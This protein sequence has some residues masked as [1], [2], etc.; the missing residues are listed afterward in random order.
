MRSTLCPTDQTKSCEGAGSSRGRICAVPSDRDVAAFDERAATYD[1]GWLGRLHHEISDKTAAIAAAAAKTPERV[2]DVGCGTGYLL[3]VLMSRLPSTTQFSGID[4]APGMIERAIATLNEPQVSLAVGVAESLPYPDGSFD[5]VVS[6]TSFDHW[7]DQKR[8]L[9]EC[10]RVLR[11]GGLLV[12]VD[13][14]SNLLLPTLV[15]SRRHK[16]RTKRRANA[17]LA[18]VGFGRFDWH[19]IYSPIIKGVTAAK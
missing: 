16:A 7:A 19:D 6:T 18:S 14:F 12:L 15:G 9:S 8:G 1:S 3:S 4:A 17:L 5:L 11:A 2:L 10:H 13:Q